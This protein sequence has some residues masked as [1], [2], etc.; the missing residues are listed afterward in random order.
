MQYN[1]NICT[2]NTARVLLTPRRVLTSEKVIS[3]AT[4]NLPLPMQFD[5]GE[6][7]LTVEIPLT[8]G[9]IAIVDAVDGDLTQYKWSAYDKKN[10]PYAGRTAYGGGSRWLVLMHRVILERV[11]NRPLLREEKVD[12]WNGNG[13]DNRRENLRL[14]NNAQ[15]ARN[16]K[17]SVVNKT[18]YKGVS[19]EKNP[20]YKS[21]WV[22]QIKVNGKRIH[23]GH[24]ATPEDAYVAYCEAA[25]KYH[26]EFARFE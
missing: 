4:S 24:F 9:Y 20:N 16:R 13:L 8:K 10:L 15:N 2:A 5:N 22:A 17:R 1:K 26:G 25:Q 6:E 11:L 23:L 21:K 3:M 14:A 18:G 7:P 12:H 19:Y